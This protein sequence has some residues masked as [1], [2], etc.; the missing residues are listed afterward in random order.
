VP[1]SKESAYIVGGGTKGVI[2]AADTK[3]V[4]ESG[5]TTFYPS[6]QQTVALQLPTPGGAI[7]EHK[8]LY[9]GPCKGQ[10]MK[11]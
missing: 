6:S 10:Q 4:S 1:G 9:R 11:A 8:V 3:A 5:H 7:P 2:F